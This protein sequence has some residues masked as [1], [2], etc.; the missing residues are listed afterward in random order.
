M[1]VK[2]IGTIALYR[3]LLFRRKTHVSIV[4]KGLLGVRA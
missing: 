4:S 1:T 3:G 2:I